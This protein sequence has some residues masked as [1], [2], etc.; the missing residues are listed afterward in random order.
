MT[1][2]TGFATAAGARPSRDIPAYHT[3]REAERRHRERKMRHK[4]MTG[5]EYVLCGVWWKGYVG[6]WWMP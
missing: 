6:W 2:R 4:R 5:V 3:H 1:A